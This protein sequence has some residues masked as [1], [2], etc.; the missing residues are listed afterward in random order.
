MTSSILAALLAIAALVYI[1]FSGRK[2]ATTAL[3]LAF[4]TLGYISGNDNTAFG[5][6]IQGIV[7]AIT[8]FV[9]WIAGAF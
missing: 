1:L 8:T 9:D 3:V 4:I 5:G 7:D 2:L 6:W